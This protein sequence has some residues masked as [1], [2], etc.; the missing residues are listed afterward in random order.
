MTTIEELEKLL[1]EATADVSPPR[2]LRNHAWIVRGNARDRL[3]SSV[4]DWLPALLEVAKAA[5]RAVMSLQPTAN[6]GAPFRCKGC[7]RE[8]EQ[9]DAAS[10]GRIFHY[11][12]CAYA[13]LDEALGQ[14][15]R[16][17][18]G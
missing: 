5:Q 11:D 18:N 2:D 1:G 15:K 14:L 8:T 7:G 12:L 10:A 4:Y 9:R 13:A 17:A 3:E 16:Q 6:N